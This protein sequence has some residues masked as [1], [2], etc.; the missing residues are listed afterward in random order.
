MDRLLGMVDNS[1]ELSELVWN[2]LVTLPKNQILS[3][4]ETNF[5]LSREDFMGN[6]CD[7]L[8]LKEIVDTSYVA[9]ALYNLLKLF[10]E[11]KLEK[12]N[13]LEKQRERGCLKFLCK[14]LRAN[15]NTNYTHITM[16][17][18][19]Y[20]L[21]L[22]NLLWD[23]KYIKELIKDP[24]ADFNASA[25]IIK[26]TLIKAKGIITSD[27][28]DTCFEFHKNLLKFDTEVLEPE[29]VSPDYLQ[30]YKYGM[31]LSNE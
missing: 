10:N 26:N 4:K 22:I 11:K 24:I 20:C 31:Y 23:T 29:I 8:E 18:I 2:F 14:I 17:I 7:F 6:W 3:K 9:Y 13:Y 5:N 15:M 25:D 30:L 1:A 12:E 19:Q 21:N 27:I 28:L 16:K